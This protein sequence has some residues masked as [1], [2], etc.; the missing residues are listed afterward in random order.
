MG[1]GLMS[2]K[3]LDQTPKEI[4]DAGMHVVIPGSIYL[5]ITELLATLKSNAHDNRA[6]GFIVDLQMALETHSVPV[7]P[8]M[9]PDNKE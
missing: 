5:T 1:N 7:K 2:I 8:R 3:E 9:A 6:L 4:A